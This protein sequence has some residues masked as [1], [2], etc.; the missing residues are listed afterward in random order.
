MQKQSNISGWRIWLYWFIGLVIVP[1]IF[2][3][4]LEV[5]LRIF[6]FGYSTSF[7]KKLEG[8]KPAIYIGNDKFSW[9]FFPPDLGQMP[10][11]FAIP[12]VKAP[13]TYRI[14][15]LGGSAAEGDPEPTYGFAP[16]LET[17][18]E[19]QYPQVNFEIID[20]AIT[21][22]NSNVVLQVAKDLVHHQPDMFI[23][24][25][26][27]NEVIGPFGAGTVFA[28]YSPNLFM[29]RAG[30]AVRSTRIG[31]L[32]NNLLARTKQNKNG[33]RRCELA[34]FLNNQ[35]RYDAPA[36]RKVYDHF[37]QNLKDVFCTVRKAGVPTII[38]TVGSNI[39]N[40]APFA[41][42]HKPDLSETDREKWD[43][44][45]KVGNDFQS[46]K[47]F[48]EAIKQYLMAAGIDDTYA[49][50][51]YRL[52][53][54][55]W[56]LGDHEQARQ[57]YIKARELDTLRFRA[58]NQINDIIRSV[59]KT[60]TAGDVY[61]VDAVKAF[62]ENSPYNTPGE[63]LFYEHVHLNFN[64]NYVLAREMFQQVSAILPD[65]IKR[66]TDDRPLLTEQECADRLAF[67]DFDKNRVL[68]F[69][70]KDRYSRPPYTNWYNYDEWLEHKK[71]EA[72]KYARSS[73]EAARQMIE[74]YRRAIGI[75]KDM[76]WLR[77]NFADLL[78]TL[79]SYGEAATQLKLYL[80]S[81]P[82]NSGA[83][84]LL[85]DSLLRLGKVDEAIIQCREALRLN[86]ALH[87][88]SYTLA[89]ALSRQGKPDESLK[90]YEKLLTEDKDQSEG[91]YNQIGMIL[92]QQKRFTEAAEAFRQAIRLNEAAGG[93]NIPDTYFNLGVALKGLGQHDE[94]V[95]FFNK[96]I[97]DY[98]DELNKI[99]QA[100]PDLL[101]A[102]GYASV[103]IG[104]FDQAVT[105]FRQVADLQPWELS[106]QFNLIKA[107]ELQ[108][109]NDEAIK[110]CRQAIQ[111][112]TQ[113]G[114]QDS[115]MKLQ[116]YLDRLIARNSI[117]NSGKSF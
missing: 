38:S 65:W 50:L 84:W 77:Y 53:Q 5:G 7:T 96:A 82:Q 2:L 88:A 8:H 41:S 21:A 4:T 48:A 55:Y 15:V 6:G 86:P 51:Q 20:A 13:N 42:L 114:R 11:D 19:D 72:A 85:G 18:L 92:S 94:A 61:L 112:M 40:C 43:S 32:L 3:G 59:A 111:S 105:Y 67:T 100:D 81:L 22:T 46:Q 113:L 52:G 47:N 44:L 107:L 16:I 115:A 116:Q 10:R 54:C 28:S 79:R 31:Q 106:N 26:G 70:L 73:P 110:A 104:D 25:V 37:Q 90:I 9:Q 39:K 71:Q 35:V 95:S 80:Q 45:F 34:L 108:G 23:V 89:D 36:L 49:E 63:E 117:N 109:K 64:G 17:L 62:R 78:I 75:Q 87:Q 83:H 68:T 29:I 57:R 60:E 97:D 14:F 76:P 33:K 66:V 58:D 103:E 24:Y 56:N 30:L 69:L 98:R 101:K 1:I 91:I 102:M 74:T 12:A 93:K 99:G 27:N